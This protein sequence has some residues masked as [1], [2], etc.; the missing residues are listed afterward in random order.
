MLIQNKELLIAFAVGTLVVLLLVGLVVFIV[1]LHN[2][3]TKRMRAEQDVIKAH[4]EGELLKAQLEIQEQ[5]LSNLSQEIHDN[6]GQMLSVI[7]VN[8]GSIESPEP[9]VSSKLD[10][11]FSLLTKVIQDL[12]DL[13][14]NLNTDYIGEKGL[15]YCVGEE[16][17]RI[18]RSGI[19][20][21][22]LEVEGEPV[23]LPEQ[24]ELMLFRVVQELL[25]NILKHAR[26]S[27]ISI[28]YG[29]AA[30]WLEIAVA[31]N[32][33]GMPIHSSGA[34]NQSLGLKSLYK[35]VGLLGGSIS[36]DGT[37]GGG[38]TVLIRIPV[39]ET[40]SAKNNVHEHY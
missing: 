36:F 15:I 34:N 40:A 5:T 7:K 12:R 13:S 9:A 31:D 29:Y 28:R 1:L 16:L 22:R 37:T 6:I 24:A 23:H 39:P 18:E 11:S 32:G 21:T 10:A 38:T 2:T 27:E 35:R 19:Y 14:R 30:P 8:I 17:E 3:K 20:A 33:V 4:Y 26:G 25:N